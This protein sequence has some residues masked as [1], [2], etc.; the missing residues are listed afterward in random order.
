MLAEG[1]LPNGVI[2]A[3][4]LQSEICIPQSAIESLCHLTSVF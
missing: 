2:C 3:N 1:S 4:L